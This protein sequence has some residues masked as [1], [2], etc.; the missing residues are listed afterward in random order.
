MKKESRQAMAGETRKGRM[1]F[2]PLPIG[3]L[4]NGDEMNVANDASTPVIHAAT[5]SIVL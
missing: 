5:A 3:H 1:A 2:Q 4:Y